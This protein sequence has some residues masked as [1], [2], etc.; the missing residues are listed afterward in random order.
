MILFM[1]SKLIKSIAVLFFALSISTGYAQ[2][3]P[4]F[5]FVMLDD[6]A[7]D[8]IF[9]NRFEFLKMPNLQRLADEGAVFENRCAH[10]F[11]CAN[12]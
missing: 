5:L 9:H 1:Q 7:P 10:L 12:R 6:M 8:A 2:E 3:K 4:N 11:L